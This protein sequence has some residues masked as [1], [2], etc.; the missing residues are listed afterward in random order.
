M[1]YITVLD[2][3]RRSVRIGV[4]VVT[5]WCMLAP[6]GVSAEQFTGKVVGVAD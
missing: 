4:A 6:L 2:V 3:C 5:L 1:R